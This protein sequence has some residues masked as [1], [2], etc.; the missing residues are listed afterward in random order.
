MRN[1]LT[2]VVRFGAC[3]SMRVAAWPEERIRSTFGAL[4][5]PHH[6]DYRC[7]VTVSGPLDQ[8]GMV[9][10]LAD[11]DRILL[12]EVV[13]LD[14]GDLNRDVAAFAGGRAFPTCEALAA[15][16]YDRVAGRLPSG[17]RLDR[18]RVAEDDSL[19]GDCTDP[20]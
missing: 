12:E 7:A 5:D 9:V 8:L 6:H 11:L 16:L 19:H 13:R 15:Y 17:V 18:V 3:H 20:G 2:R 10:N 14:G 4:A 1:S